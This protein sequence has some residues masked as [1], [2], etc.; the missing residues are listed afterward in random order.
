MG[1][2]LNINA[3]SSFPNKPIT[4]N[5]NAMLQHFLIRDYGYEGFFFYTFLQIFID[6]PN[7]FIKLHFPEKN[8]NDIRYCF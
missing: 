7:F 4:S 1:A 6:A 2:F 3:H 8:K 5:C